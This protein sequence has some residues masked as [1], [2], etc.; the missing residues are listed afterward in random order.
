VLGEHHPPTGRIEASRTIGKPS[1]GAVV[2][3]AITP[4]SWPNY[5]QPRADSN[6]IK[7]CWPLVFR[8]LSPRSHDR[9]C[10]QKP[11]PGAGLGSR[12]V[13]SI[14]RCEGR[15]RRRARR[16]HA[17][18]AFAEAPKFRAV[19]GDLHVVFVTWRVRLPESNR[20]HSLEHLILARV[21]TGPEVVL[22]RSTPDEHRLR[23]ITLRGVG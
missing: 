5:R 3:T 2:V 9:C 23:W 14:S 20:W 18:P 17:S 8:S 7:R 13:N 6:G 11:A 10:S 12:D 4:T 21:P 19:M 22:A 15:V 16:F 1:F